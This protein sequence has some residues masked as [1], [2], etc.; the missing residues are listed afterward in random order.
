MFLRRLLLTLIA[1]LVLLASATAHDLFL[2]LDTYFL[3]PNSKVTVRLMNGTFQQSD[4]AVA[5]ERL[6]DLTVITPNTRS[7]SESHFA[8]R[9]EGKTT[10]MDFET[11]QPGTY[12]MGAST[13]P[14]E[15]ELKAADF[16]DYLK[17]D[18]IPDTL[19]A[20]KRDGQL[21]KDVRERYSKHVRAVF[22]VGDTLTEDYKKAFHYPVEL[23][24]QQNPYS[25]R[26]GQT[27]SV[28][29]LLEGKPI[30][31]QF[32][33]A[34]WESRNGKLHTFAARADKNGMARITLRGAGK[35]FI[36]FIHMTPLSEPNLNYESK[37][38]S[39]T[40]EIK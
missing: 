4:G 31:N 21:G 16:N 37:W 40:F 7:L 36:K 33:M 13:R 15:I 5:R 34:G 2:R 32:V 39:L 28:L 26:A 3:K 35:W 19:A 1:V 25:L 6:Q 14:R 23:I 30:A 8:W 24:P 29:C 20:R 10:L 27:I 9:A 18:G 22:Q 12:L 17:H 11:G 38:A